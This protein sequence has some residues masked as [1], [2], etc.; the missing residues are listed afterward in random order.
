MK[1]AIDLR[2]IPIFKGDIVSYAALNNK[3]AKLRWGYVEK[4][5]ERK[6]KTGFHRRELK[7][8][9]YVTGGNLATGQWRFPEEVIVVFPRLENEA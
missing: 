4:A 5:E 9:V 1:E 3:T 7:T 6:A 8:M 2:G